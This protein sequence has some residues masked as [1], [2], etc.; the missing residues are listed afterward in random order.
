MDGKEVPM[1]KAFFAISYF[2]A[3]CFTKAD[4]KELLCHQPADGKESAD[5]KSLDSS[6]EAESFILYPNTGCY[7]QDKLHQVFHV[8]RPR[9]QDLRVSNKTHHDPSR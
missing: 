7:R 8:P 9:P 5:G 1:A 4:G 3:V 6:S 2:F